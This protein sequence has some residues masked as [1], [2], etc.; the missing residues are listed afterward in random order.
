MEPNAARFPFPLPPRTIG[1]QKA[2]VKA[3]Q[4]SVVGQFPINVYRELGSFSCPTARGVVIPITA[5][6]ELRHFHPRVIQ[7]E[8]KKEFCRTGSIIQ[9]IANKEAQGS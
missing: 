4:M 3:F 8:V 1:E 5:K 6:Y 2:K 7:I 9:R